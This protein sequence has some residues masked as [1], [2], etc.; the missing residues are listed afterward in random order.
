MKI[1]IVDDYKLVSTSL[2]TIIESD[3]EIQVVG[4]GHSG[5]DAVALFA[6]LKPDIL[7]MDE[8][9]GSLDAITKSNMQKMLLQAWRETGVTIVFVTHDINEAI[10]ISNRIA[11][12]SKVHGKLSILPNT[13]MKSFE[14]MDKNLPEIYHTVYR[15]LGE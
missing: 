8:P 15:L 14:A 9:F 13:P 2:K 1:V 11:V 6:A 12:M 3:A 5:K 7:L 10:F 4:I